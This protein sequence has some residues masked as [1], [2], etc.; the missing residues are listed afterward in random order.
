MTEKLRSLNSPTGPAKKIIVKAG[1][2][3]K[4]LVTVPIDAVR[5]TTETAIDTTIG[6]TARQ[7]GVTEPES[8]PEEKTVEPQK[9]PK[10]I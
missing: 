2:V 1:N 3:G 9:K 7:M 4:T 6:E 5:E 8:P 10:V